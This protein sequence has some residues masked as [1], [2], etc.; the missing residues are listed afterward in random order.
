MKGGWS[1]WSPAYSRAFRRGRAWLTTPPRRIF[2]TLRCGDRTI[3]RVYEPL[4]RPTR[5]D[6]R[7]EETKQ[8]AANLLQIP[9]VENLSKVKHVKETRSLYQPVC[10]W[11]FTLMRV[12]APFKIAC[13]PNPCPSTEGGRQ[14]KV[15]YSRYR[16]SD[17]NAFSY[18][19]ASNNK[20]IK[21]G[22]LGFGYQLMLSASRLRD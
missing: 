17:H 13:L 20:M 9:Y 1:C 14:L 5:Y 8:R 2:I 7:P 6:R 21:Q 12:V 3:F 11:K 19:R 10:C 4:P 16:M 15:Y 18:R 22:L